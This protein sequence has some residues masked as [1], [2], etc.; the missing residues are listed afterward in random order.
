MKLSSS[1]VVSVRVKN[2]DARLSMRTVILGAWI[3]CSK[4]PIDRVYQNRDIFSAYPCFKGYTDLNEQ[5]RILWFGAKSY[6]PVILASGYSE[7]RG[8]TAESSSVKHP[9]AGGRGPRERLGSGACILYRLRHH[10]QPHPSWAF[11]ALG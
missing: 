1:I 9:S 6:L 2:Q 7:A 10:I 5:R 8:E 11:I 4:T 3:G